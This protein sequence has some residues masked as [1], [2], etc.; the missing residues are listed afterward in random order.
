MI[1]DRYFIQPFECRHVGCGK[2]F[3]LEFN[4]RTHMRVHTGD[5]PYGCPV[6]GCEKKFSQSTNLKSHLLTH[7]RNAGADP[8]TCDIDFDGIDFSTLDEKH[9]R[10]IRQVLQLAGSRAA[11]SVPK[12]RSKGRK[13][14]AAGTSDERGGVSSH[15]CDSPQSLVI[16]TDAV[17]NHAESP[18]AD[19]DPISSNSS[20]NG[21]AIAP[22]PISHRS[23]SHPASMAPPTVSL[24]DNAG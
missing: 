18:S 17:T 1:R 11:A 6:D 10:A 9:A 3:S 15:A 20:S 21:A 12:K 19:A 23:P 4:L 8:E 7:V 14:P 22:S 16:D 5:R 13:R 24:L 2:R